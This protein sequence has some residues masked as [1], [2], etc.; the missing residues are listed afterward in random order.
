MKERAM[1]GGSTVFC[2]MSESLV[3]LA[4]TGDRNVRFNLTEGST[5]I[6]TV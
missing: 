2:W 6:Y 3:V 1:C 4:L 5:Y